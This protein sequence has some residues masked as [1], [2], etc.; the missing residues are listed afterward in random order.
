MSTWIDRFAAMSVTDMVQ[1]IVEDPSTLGALL[2]EAIRYRTG[3]VNHAIECP[4]CQS[5]AVRAALRN[6]NGSAGG[7]LV[8]QA[9]ALSRRSRRPVLPRGTCPADPPTAQ[10]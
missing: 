2:D 1:T 5:T 4:Q 6:L 8:G 7:A 9:E 10:G 3:L